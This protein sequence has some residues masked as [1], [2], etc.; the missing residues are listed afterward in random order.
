MLRLPHA[1]VERALGALRALRGGVGAHFVRALLE[2][3][4]KPQDGAHAQGT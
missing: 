2:Q 4:V 1:H 3:A